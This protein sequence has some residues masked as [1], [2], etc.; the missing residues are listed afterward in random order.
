MCRE[1]LS[2]CIQRPHHRE[3]SAFQK[4]S[5]ICNP[6]LRKLHLGCGEI[7]IPGFINIDVQERPGVDVVADIRTLHPRRFPPGSVDLIYASHVLEHVGRWD[8]PT[9]LRRWHGLLKD[10]GV[11]RLAV[12]DLHALSKIYLETGDLSLI[13]GPLYGGQH[14]PGG[15]HYWGWDQKTLSRDLFEAGFSLV[16]SWDW[17]TT[18]HSFV[19][20]FSQAYVPHMQKDTGTLISLNLEAVK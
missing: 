17:R 6:H 14:C 8:F 16:R 1:D 15:T 3:M 10:N 19:D 20:D 12:P 13:L 7:H 5:I 9:V 2:G 18:E 11:L 4:R